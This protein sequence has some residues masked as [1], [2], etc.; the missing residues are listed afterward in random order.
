MIVLAKPLAIVW[1]AHHRSGISGCWEVNCL[2]NVREVNFHVTVLQHIR[3]QGTYCKS[4]RILLNED[5]DMC[6]N[7]ERT[8]LCAL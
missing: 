6:R 3:A 1:L 5:L 4:R 8:D 2:G 7:T